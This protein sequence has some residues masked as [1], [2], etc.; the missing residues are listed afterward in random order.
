MKFKTEKFIILGNPMRKGY[1]ILYKHHWWN[2]WKY[3][4]TSDGE[5]KEYND[6][7]LY[8]IINNEKSS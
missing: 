8:N 4:L 1:N 6:V 3:I 2:K 5:C 7:E